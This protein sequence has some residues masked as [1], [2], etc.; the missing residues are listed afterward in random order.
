MGVVTMTSTACAVPPGAGG[1]AA[2]I[3]PSDTTSNCAATPPKVTDVALVK[4]E[5]SRVTKVPPATAP[6]FGLMDK[7]AG[8]GGLSGM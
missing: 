6:K 7:T 8:L 1:L 3:C 2:T 4:P 5:P